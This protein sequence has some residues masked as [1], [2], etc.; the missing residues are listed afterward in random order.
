VRK[1]EE[2]YIAYGI[3]SDIIDR[4]ILSN[5]KKKLRLDRNQVK[6]SK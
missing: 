1:I 6:R 4:I 2:N 3:I 5:P